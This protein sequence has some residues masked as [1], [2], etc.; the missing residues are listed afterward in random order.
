MNEKKLKFSI[1]IPSYNEGEDIRL[2]LESVRGQNYLGDKEIFVVDDSS[3]NTPDIIREYEKDG[4]IY[5]RGEKKGCCGARNIGMNLAS[6]DVVVLLNADVILPPDFFDRIS[7]HYHHGADYVLVESRVSNQ[8]NIWARFVEAQHRYESEKMK[9]NMEWTEG[10]SCRKDAAQKVGFIDGDFSI[11][12]CRDW[13]LGQKLKQAGFKKVIDR[14]IVVTHKAPDHFA[15][16]WRV[17]KAR[18]RFSS[19][20]QY[21]LYRRPFLWLLFKFFLKDTL[22]ILKFVVFVPW[23]WK[24]FSITKNVSGHSRFYG[25][26][27]KFIYAYFIQEIARMT[28]EWQGLFMGAKY[29]RKEKR[30]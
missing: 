8:E 16:Y 2:S 26:F 11:T 17:R 19:L 7:M 20:M 18:G 12:F 3:D 4:V 13:T 9:E 23:V 15:E 24:V 25:N 21:L 14:E 10:F 1:V 22:F 29:K 6:G 28:G 5:V 30:L 27:F